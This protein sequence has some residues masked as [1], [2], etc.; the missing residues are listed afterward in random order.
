MTSPGTIAYLI[1][2]SC[3]A[4][5]DCVNLRHD[6]LAI[7]NN[8]FGFRGSQ[9]DMQNRSVFGHVDPLAREHVF[10]FVSEAN[11]LGEPDKQL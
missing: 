5:E 2:E 11:V 9:C 1:A 6:V 10:D 7:D 3:H 4:V 8:R